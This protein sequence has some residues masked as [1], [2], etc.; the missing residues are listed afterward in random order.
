MKFK[1]II[2][3]PGYFRVN[4]E[5]YKQLKNKFL[6]LSRKRKDHCVCLRLE[7][8]ELI[9]HPSADELLTELIKEK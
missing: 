1:D 9:F 2:I 6:Q 7:K 8:L 3:P 5:I 4:G